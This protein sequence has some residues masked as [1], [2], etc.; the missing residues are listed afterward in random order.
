M[1]FLHIIN[2]V[3]S[4]PWLI[5]PSYHAN[6]RQVVRERMLTTGAQWAKDRDGTDLSGEAVALPS[7]RITDGIAEIPVP[8][9]ILKG[10]TAFEKGLGAVAVED[11]MTDLREAA[12]NDDV[13]GVFLDVDSPG[14][15]V[16]G[17][18]ELGDLVAEV[19]RIKPVRV[20]TDGMLCSAAYWMAAGA[21]DIVASRSADVGSIG[22]YVPWIDDSEAFAMEGV[23]VEIITNEGADLKGM[24]YPGT[25]LTE[26]QRAELVASVNE[27][28]DEFH[29]H[30][31]AYR[32]VHEPAD[33]FRGQ[34]FTAKT[35][36]ARGLV[37]DVMDRVSALEDF[38]EV[39]SS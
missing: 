21:T 37:D 16:G 36:K 15:T 8:G 31:L 10:A 33:T 14:G 24:G 25:S 38:R 29:E 12:E 22:V 3:Y 27:T 34:S 32:S 23:T 5:L 4:Q 1:R 17:V 20:F 30:V 6:I 26:A 35:A 7:M 39:L 19:A 13:S 9:V 28:A 18:P 2:A 11:V